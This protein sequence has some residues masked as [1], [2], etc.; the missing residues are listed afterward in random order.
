M[1]YRKLVEGHHFNV[2][3][4]ACL[5]GRLEAVEEALNVYKE[6]NG[7]CVNWGDLIDEVGWS[8]LHFASRQSGQAIVDLLLRRG[9][10]PLIK[11]PEGNTPLHLA[12][13]NGR[14]E[15]VRRLLEASL[16]PAAALECKNSGGNTP[17]HVACQERHAAVV[18]ELL[19]CSAP[20]TFSCGCNDDGV[21]PLG[22]A[23]LNSDWES[24]RLL[25]HHSPENPALFFPDLAS[26]V[27]A[28]SVMKTLQDDPLNVFVMGDTNSG[29]STFVKTLQTEGM[30]SRLS[31][32]VTTTIFGV[33]HVDQ[34]RVGVIPT[35]TEFMMGHGQKHQIV[36]Y[37]LAGHRDYTHEAIF[38][39]IHKPLE[40]LFVVTVDMRD[41]DSEIESKL[42]YWMDFIWHKCSR[43]SS[44]AK[45]NVLVLGT[46][47]DKCTRAYHKLNLIC[48]SI[49]D[50]TKEQLVSHFTWLGN[51]TVNCRWT[52]SWG[53]YQFRSVLS[54]LCQQQETETHTPP[55]CYLLGS[56]ILTEQ[57]F[58]SEL[59]VSVSQVTEH[60]CTEDSILCKLLPQKAAKL[61]ELGHMLHHF[62]C[63]R[64]LSCL[65]SQNTCYIIPD[66]RSF[67]KEVHEKLSMPSLCQSANH[68]ILRLDSIAEV[69]QCFPC[70][71]IIEF[72]ES[73]KFCEGVPPV[74]LLKLRKSISTSRHSLKFTS[75][76]SESS[77]QLARPTHHRTQSTASAQEV[78]TAAAIP[79][80]AGRSHSQ[81]DDLDMM[82]PREP[83]PDIHPR[84]KNHPPPPFY[85][86]PIFIPKTP[87]DSWEN[88][89]TYTYSFAWTLEA[90]RGQEHE[91]FLP[92]FVTVLLFCFSHSF[93]PPPT[94]ATSILETRCNIW[95]CGV[96]WTDLRGI[97]V[98]VSIHNN[99]SIVISMRCVRK[100]EMECLQLR[101][102]IMD[103][104]YNL[105]DRLHS[106]TQINEFLVPGD[107]NTMFPVYDPS[108]LPPQSCYSKDE[109]RR[110]VL[111][112]HPVVCNLEGKD[113]K[114]LDTLLYFEPSCVLDQP[115]REKLLSGS[116]EPLSDDFCISFAKQLGHRWKHLAQY[117]ELPDAYVSDIERDKQAAYRTGVEMLRHLRDSVDHGVHTYRD[118]RESLQSISIFKYDK[119]GTV[120]SRK[121]L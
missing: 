103:H 74:S 40:S 82:A 32:I 120:L 98:C 14:V 65:D 9:F 93:A 16:E 121:S 101:N 18:K 15:I 39:G 89:D 114:D 79:L 113:P 99:R 72:L 60:V 54:N 83:S 19:E 109:I 86:F 69:L 36:F 38:E 49:P 17:L 34:H 67:L 56:L 21:T 57:K 87:P 50:Q 24:A 53:M 64:L 12:S 7:H 47:A 112:N 11:T 61:V 1:A 3:S 88:N 52:F 22:L 33:Q 63:I 44:Q 106:E 108:Q 8:P 28:C 96:T 43:Y 45:P 76:S 68:G 6:A 59:V 70:N 97:E 29:K 104:I 94:N 66:Y 48:R 118:L 95:D 102:Q 119:V 84:M 2:I 13:Q 77:L 80:P 23:I 107:G 116:N 10:P 4:A 92:Q 90:A 110:A 117:Y 91:H 111:E 41:D 55:E 30:V 46:F 37:D 100:A 75:H 25:I 73:F 71:F 81:P 62:S 35:I 31:S 105:K 85:F 115:L 26:H 58:A 27:P 78:P 51:F 5:E 42:I 20:T